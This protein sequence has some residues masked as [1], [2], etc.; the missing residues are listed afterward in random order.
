MIMF[1]DSVE[2]Q[3]CV[4]TFLKNAKD[5]YLAAQFPHADDAVSIVKKYQPDIV[6][7]DIQM[8][9]HKSGI[10]AMVDIL[11]VYPE[12]KVIILTFYP[13]DDK[14]FAALQLGA[15]G[16]LAKDEIE[17]LEKVIHD[18]DRGGG[19]Y[20]PAVCARIASFFRDLEK[21]KM[22]NYVELTKREKEVL[23]LMPTRSRKMIADDLFIVE[24]TVNFHIKNIFK[25]L[26]VNSAT[27]AV[28]KAIFRKLIDWEKWDIC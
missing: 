16:F 19:Y 14:I 8:P 23:S 18:V 7:M 13:E 4:K 6:L 20:T 28:T 5:I 9:K 11:K 10:N 15:K 26:E 24:E 27:E 22:D 25:K 21:G 12:T 17:D 3:D 1:D 2:Y